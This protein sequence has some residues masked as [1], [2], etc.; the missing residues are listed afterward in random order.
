M[1]LV[2]IFLQGRRYRPAESERLRQLRSVGSS[3]TTAVRPQQ[4]SRGIWVTR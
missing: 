2:L 4:T 3:L 1:A